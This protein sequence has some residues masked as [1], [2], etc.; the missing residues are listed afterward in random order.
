MEWIPVIHEPRGNIVDV[1]DV[2]GLL[3][4]TEHSSGLEL[5]VDVIHLVLFGLCHLGGV[6]SSRR[7][8]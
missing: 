2:L 1:I 5:G 8:V 3:D 7:S 4:C 6:A